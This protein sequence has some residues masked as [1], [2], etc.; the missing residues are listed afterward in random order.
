MAMTQAELL[1][2][3]DSDMESDSAEW[4][5]VCGEQLEEI[6]GGTTQE[7]QGFMMRWNLHIRKH[8]LHADADV[9]DACAAFAAAHAADLAGDGPL[10]RCF[11]AHLTNLWRFRLVK[12]AQVHAV[13]A[14]L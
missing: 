11:V 1:D 14:G 2:G 13:L 9:G 6:G 3:E 12:P 4:A 7:E 8:P 5:R 10:R